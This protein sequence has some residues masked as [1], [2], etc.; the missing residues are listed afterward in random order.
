MTRDNCGQLEKV[1]GGTHVVQTAKEYP[2]MGIVPYFMCNL[3]V[4]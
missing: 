4:N 2:K 3:A 1:L